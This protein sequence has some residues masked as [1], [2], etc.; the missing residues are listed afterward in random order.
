MAGNDEKSPHFAYKCFK[1]ELFE[2]SPFKMALGGL[3]LAC[4]GPWKTLSNLGIVLRFW[5]PIWCCF[6]PFRAK[7]TLG[8]HFT[9]HISI[10]VCEIGRPLPVVSQMLR[11]G[12]LGPAENW[13][14]GEALETSKGV[15]LEKIFAP[16]KGAPFGLETRYFA[17]K[18]GVSW[19]RNLRCGSRWPPGWGF[20]RADPG[21]VV[22]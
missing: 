7:L 22:G 21:W 12:A 14:E 20:S 16:K 13:S 11:S 8:C 18:R 6:W 1:I 10:G 19:G 9:P 5:P 15:A 3:R 4:G 17:P 2:R